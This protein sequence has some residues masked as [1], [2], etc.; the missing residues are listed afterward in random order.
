[1]VAR[2]GLLS[3]LVTFVPVLTWLASEGSVSGGTPAANALYL[4][5]EI[6]RAGLTLNKIIKNGEHLCL[7]C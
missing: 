2:A 4:D 3:D 6:I 5:G 1:V 7:N